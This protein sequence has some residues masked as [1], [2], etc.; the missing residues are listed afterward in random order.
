MANLRTVHFDLPGASKHIRAKSTEE[1]SRPIPRL[2]ALKRSQT[3]VSSR[4]KPITKP[5]GEVTVQFKAKRSKLPKKGKQ[6]FLCWRGTH[7]KEQEHSSDEDRADN[8]GPEREILREP[9]KESHNKRATP[10]KGPKFVVPQGP[11][12]S[13]PERD[14]S[15]QLFSEQGRGVLKA[16]PNTNSKVLTELRIEDLKRPYRRPRGGELIPEGGTLGQ[17]FR[18]PEGEEV[19]QRDIA[20]QAC[21]ESSTKGPNQVET[22][23]GDSFGE[24]PRRDSYPEKYTKPQVCREEEKG[25]L[26]QENSNRQVNCSPKS[27]VSSQR[28]ENDR[29]LYKERLRAIQRGKPEYISDYKRLKSKE[30]K[31]D[32]EPL[33]PR[34]LKESGEMISRLQESLFREKKIA[35]AKERTIQN[36]KQ[37]IRILDNDLIEKNRENVKLSEQLSNGKCR[38]LS[39]E[40]ENRILA[41]QVRMYEESNRRIYK[42]HMELRNKFRKQ[43]A[44]ME[45][46]KMQR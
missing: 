8:K 13:I 23:N 37:E 6:G 39:M 5:F 33:Y 36:M 15:Y 12:V 7:S 31:M 38:M 2:P 34:D 41:N 44:K 42:A 19:I 14:N 9:K 21:N 24:L 16:Q 40:T 3:W 27:E 30:K 10:E 35:E 43:E 28:E 45:E 11:P 26:L 29:L 22:N 46:M 25:N 4:E 1:L 18:E 17:I 20:Y 32:F